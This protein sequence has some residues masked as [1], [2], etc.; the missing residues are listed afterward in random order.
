MSLEDATGAQSAWG[1]GSISAGTTSV[2]VDDPDV[3]MA[4]EALSGLGKLGMWFIFFLFVKGSL[5]C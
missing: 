4:A 1:S 2:S 5:L 3:R